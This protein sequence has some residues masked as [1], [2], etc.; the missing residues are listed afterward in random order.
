MTKDIR[1]YINLFVDG[2]G[3]AGQIKDFDPPK[4]ALKME[5][6]RAG[7]M[8]VPVEI[9]MGMEKMEA[10]FT[11][12]SY[13]LDVL[14]LWGVGVGTQVPFLAREALES[15][16]GTVKYVEHTMRGR[17]RKMDAGTSKPGEAAD[18][19]VEMALDY[20]KL[21]HNGTLVHEIDGPNMVRTVNGNDVLAAFRAALLR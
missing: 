5:E 1:K 16:D 20:Y 6:F 3:Y 10:S 19:K 14:G 11:L 18:L 15:H 7:G 2:K 13:S 8:E 4:L 17:I 9:P 12:R 21:I